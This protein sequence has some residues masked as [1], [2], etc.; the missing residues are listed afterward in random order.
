VNISEY[1]TITGAARLTAIPRQTLAD[2]VQEGR[3]RSWT[4]ACGLQMVSVAG[5]RRLKRRPRGRPRKVV[6]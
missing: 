6:S 1:A 5:V 3:L 4:T 2:A